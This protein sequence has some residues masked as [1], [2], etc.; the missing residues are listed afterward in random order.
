MPIVGI[1]LSG[2][3]CIEHFVCFFLL[4][5][6][7]FRLERIRKWI[8][9]NTKNSHTSTIRDTYTHR[10]M[11]YMRLYVGA[12][13]KELL[14]TWISR[15]LCL[16]VRKH[17]VGVEWYTF[18]ITVELTQYEAKFCVSF[19]SF[20]SKAKWYL[21][22]ICMIFTCVALRWLGFFKLGEGLSLYAAALH[23]PTGGLNV[24]VAS[25]CGCASSAI[26]DVIS[27]YSSWHI[28]QKF[29]PCHQVKVPL[30]AFENHRPLHRSLRGAC[31]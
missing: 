2:C 31:L 27:V 16:S 3:L 18:S 12:K 28:S 6:F 10:I 30:R 21:A 15:I 1:R 20:P 19:S 29:L 11:R 4:L 9:R 17:H 26:E 5:L 23:V 13:S 14:K 7:T 8:E 24:I 25:N 22:C